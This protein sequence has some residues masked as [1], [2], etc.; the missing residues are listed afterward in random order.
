MT[1]EEFFQWLSTCP[2]SWDVI[3][4]DDGKIW[5]EFKTLQD[6]NVEEG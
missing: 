3:K 6:N 5:V 2:I 1:K 4:Y